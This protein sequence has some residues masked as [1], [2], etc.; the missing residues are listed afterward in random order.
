MTRAGKLTTV[1]SF[2]ALKGCSDGA[3]PNGPLVEGLDGGFYGTANYQIGPARVGSLFRV[4]LDGR[5]TTL[6]YF[7]RT[8]YCHDGGP[9][10]A[11]LTRAADGSFY[12]ATSGGGIY[13][14]GL[15]YHI[16]T[17]GQYSLVYNFCARGGCF[18]GA[19]PV[20]APTLGSDGNLYGATVGG[21]D[22]RNVGTLYQ[23]TP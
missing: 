13:Y 16:T 1:Y 21:G 9:P 3:Q 2:C 8:E 10:A 18:D 23:L 12:G 6:H 7:C 20:I 22:K 11:G 17:A 19:T 15:I 14:N 5:L 4:T